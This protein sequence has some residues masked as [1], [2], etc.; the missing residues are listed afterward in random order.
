M[1]EEILDKITEGI[2]YLLNGKKKPQ[3]VELPA[4][5]PDNEVKQVVSYFN[6][7]LKEYNDFAGHMASTSRGELDFSDIESKMQVVQDYKN[8]RSNLKHLTWKTQRI[9]QGDFSQRIDFMG[10]FSAAFNKM[11]QQLKDAFEKIEAQNEQ[12]KEANQ[13]ISQEKDKSE[14][15][16]LNTLP[17]KVV[18]DL[19]QFGKTEP[20]SFDNVTVFF[21][22]IV[23]F[24]NK[25]MTIEPKPLILELSKMFTTFDDIMTKN[26]CERI[27][28]IGDAYLAVC[29]MPKADFNH[30]SNMLNASIS[31]MKYL[32]ARPK[33]QID[34]QIRIGIHSGKVVGGIV[35]IR[36]YLYDVFG[37]TINTASRMESNSE[38]MRINVSETTYNLTRDRFTF[39]EREPIEVKG[40]GK[41]K[42][43]FLEPYFPH[44]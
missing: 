5:Y 20:E 24:T 21:S 17:L 34:W 4:D 7:L 6:K 31:I 16:L 26:H 11:T 43:Y 38:P 42:M 1:Q 9:S 29:G 44:L 2:Y 30:A 12:L 22:D 37:D 32:Q 36:K 40:K 39:S 25:S 14:K 13:V 33:A 8:L 23:G 28:T 10:D 19:K 41:M 15:L 18:E 35:G 3:I 27:K